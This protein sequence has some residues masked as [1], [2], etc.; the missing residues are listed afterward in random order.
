MASAM[1]R[2]LVRGSTFYRH[3]GRSA[4]ESRTNARSALNSRRLARS[5]S[6][7][8]HPLALGWPQ[9]F[10]ASTGAAWTP[11]QVLDD[12]FGASRP[13]RSHYPEWAHRAQCVQT[14]DK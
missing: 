7:A 11:D 8:N 6:E 2:E 10:V 1:T 4:A 13:E 14:L 12:A 3:P 9:A 5:V